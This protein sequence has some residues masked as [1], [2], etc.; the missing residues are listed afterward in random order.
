MAS[1]T[2]LARTRLLF[3]FG[4]VSLLPHRVEFGHGS[5]VQH[6]VRRRRGGAD[7]VAEF[8]GTEDALLLAR[9]EHP[10]ITA[11]RA[12]INLAVGD[13]RRGPHFTLDLVRPIRLPGLRIEAMDLPAEVR[14][15]QQPILHRHGAHHV[16]LQRIRPPLAG[17][18]D[19]AAP[20][21]VDALQPR[22]V[23][24]PKRIAAASHIDAVFVK[25]RHAI[26]VAGTFA[27]VAVVTVH[28]LLWRRRIE[29]ELPDL[30]QLL[31]F[32]RRGRGARDL[33]GID[34]PVAAG[35]KEEWPAVHVA[36]RGRRPRAMEDARGDLLVIARDQPPAG[37]VQHDQAWGVRRANPLVRV[38]DPGAG[39]EVEA[40]AVD[41]NRAVRRVVR[42]NARAGGQ[43]KAPKN[44]RAGRARLARMRFARRPARIEA[45]HFA[46]IVDQINAVA[47]DGDG[48]GDA[49]LGPV[50]VGVLLALGHGQLPEEA[51]VFFVEAHEHAAVA[52]VPRVAWLAV[53]GADEETAAGDDGCGMRFGPEFR[54][55]IDIFAGLRVEFL[56]QAP[57]V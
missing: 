19:I 53:V 14:D 57:L 43:I 34:D 48:R 36:E 4:S 42:P 47:L 30:L 28:V 15:E 38:I 10:E 29:V 23:L 44:G 37:L 20:A 9:G 54:A 13:Q 6:P 49:G 50:E 32:A 55:P 3:I 7:G 45:H 31:H 11:P 8:D 40:I 35:K 51:P 17:A 18:R 1:I 46:A 24:P 21:R 27:A 2:A 39:I 56:G 33:K 52:L 5:D 16:P 22:L 41:E 26:N 25:D 12:Q